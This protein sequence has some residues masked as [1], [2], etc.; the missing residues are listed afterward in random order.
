MVNNYKPYDPNDDSERSSGASYVPTRREIKEKREELEEQRIVQ[1]SIDTSQPFVKPIEQERLEQ[2]IRDQEV[3]LRNQES[4]A[5]LQADYLK[6]FA[7][8]NAKA[9]ESYKVEVDQKYDEIQKW[10]D[11]FTPEEYGMAQGEYQKNV[12]SKIKEFTDIQEKYNQ[13]VKE[14]N[15]SYDTF[16]TELGIAIDDLKSTDLEIKK[17]VA[18]YN[19]NLPKVP[20]SPAF[21]YTGTD[22]GSNTT[23]KPDFDIQP[24]FSRTGEDIGNNPGIP[25]IPVAPDF[26]Q[27]GDDKGER[28]DKDVFIKIFQE[29]PDKE[30]SERFVESLGDI[31][32]GTFQRLEPKYPNTKDFSPDQELIENRKW[33]DISKG[34][35][36]DTTTLTEITRTIAK[37][38][39]PDLPLAKKQTI[40]ERID[41]RR[42]S[43]ISNETLALLSLG[44]LGTKPTKEDIEYAKKVVQDYKDQPSNKQDVIRKTGSWVWDAVI[45]EPGKA[46]YDGA[47]DIA[48]YKSNQLQQNPLGFL[49]TSISPASF[50]LDSFSP[51]DQSIIGGMWNGVPIEEQKKIGLGEMIYDTPQERKKI[52]NQLKES[53]NNLS[54][55]SGFIQTFKGDVSKKW[56]NR[57]TQQKLDELTLNNQKINFENRYMKIDDPYIRAYES[58]SD[59]EKRI[60]AKGGSTAFGEFL[61]L[62]SK[63]VARQSWNITNPV[64]TVTFIGGVGK[65]ALKGLSKAIN[66]VVKAGKKGV[67]Q[68][69]T[70]NVV[71]QSTFLDQKT[72][73]IFNVKKLDIGVNKTPVIAIER[74]LR[75]PLKRTLKDLPNYLTQ[76][77][78]KKILELQ[79]A[80]QKNRAYKKFSYDDYFIG[81]AVKGAT[82]IDKRIKLDK[83]QENF[84][85]T[86]SAS[87]QNI[88]KIGEKIE[89]YKKNFAKKRP[90]LKNE[91]NNLPI[92]SKQ[93][94]N[95]YKQ[96][97]SKQKIDNLAKEYT[98]KQLFQLADKST[99]RYTSKQFKSVFDDIEVSIGKSQTKKTLKKINDK[100]KN[101]DTE[102]AKYVN[103]LLDSVRRNSRNDLERYF[104]QN[105]KETKK[106]KDGLESGKWKKFDNESIRRHINNEVIEESNYIDYLA[107]PT[108]NDPFPLGKLREE[109]GKQYYKSIVD[110][111]PINE[112]AKRLFLDQFRNDVKKS[113]FSNWYDPDKKQFISATGK[114]EDISKLY[115]GKSVKEY[116]DEIT[117]KLPKNIKKNLD[118]LSDNYRIQKFNPIKST[119][120]SIKAPKIAI[121]SQERQFI[122]EPGI[123]KNNETYIDDQKRMVTQKQLKPKR[124]AKSKTKV[125][126]Y[127][128]ITQPLIEPL[129]IPSFKPGESPEIPKRQ[130]L[131][132]PKRQLKPKPVSIPGDIGVEKNPTKKLQTL[133][134]NTKVIDKQKTTVKNKFE[135]PINPKPKTK[136]NTKPGKTKEKIKV[137]TKVPGITPKKKFDKD[138]KG[139]QKKGIVIPRLSKSQIK[140]IKISK[141]KNPSKVGWKQGEFYPIVDLNKSTIEFRKNKPDGLKEGKKPIDSFTVLQTSN[142]KPKKQEFDFGK[143]QAK[144]NGEV[145]FRLKR[146]RILP[147]QQ[148]AKRNKLRR[149]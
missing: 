65:G 55:E 85:S 112:N 50:I 129:T 30:Q 113:K 58:L 74:E 87:D 34:T 27:T 147:K 134:S 130:P 2:Q 121:L 12:D 40:A 126:N 73:E 69:T 56:N 111:L 54:S 81:D 24:D 36:P 123:Q 139:F 118:D 31:D 71:S 136:T 1:E 37:D 146:K 127:Q 125:L 101:S 106:L 116:I 3:Q 22:I 124:V 103:G 6:T 100:L 66:P 67:V 93:V 75:T 91:I 8:E 105:A 122:N 59:K 78:K 83:A 4:S 133:K 88:K 20:S 76:P 25:K 5:Q 119:S 144:I 14:Y 114:S 86:I 128:T 35:S 53:W 43:L 132:K 52:I 120:K 51:K 96:I 142:L 46:L 64:L 99:Q 29:N 23:K 110:D 72:G 9:I 97:L 13:S 107:R 10:I 28:T 33:N 117:N 42:K 89:S 39:S 41:E 44:G 7:T 60:L 138:K 143:F 104:R 98:A 15:D 49:A 68:V 149:V 137:K 115:G 141:G 38:T 19:F 16:K 84:A 148:L 70:K 77:A 131:K 61:T 11:G 62:A 63:E 82:R 17:N 47:G 95:E 18:Q 48:S 102:F 94:Y 26:S 140:S 90:E 80:F 45:I 79:Q 57:R 145:S 109:W 108:V 32:K 135:E 92:V 21:D